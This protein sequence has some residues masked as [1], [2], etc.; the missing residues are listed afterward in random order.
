[1][2]HQNG[3]DHAPGVVL[4]GVEQYRQC[5]PISHIS[6]IQSLQV[7]T[8]F[9]RLN[10]GGI[11]GYLFRQGLPNEAFIK[12]LQRKSADSTVK[13]NLK[14]LAF[15]FVFWAVGIFAVVLPVFAGEVLR[16]RMGFCCWKG[17]FGEK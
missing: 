13:V 14:Q 9:S 6:R 8:L 17:I 11:D 16:E 7:Q 4:I 12:R 2:R 1:M 3:I 10:G 5:I 15:T